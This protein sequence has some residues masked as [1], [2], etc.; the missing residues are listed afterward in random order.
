MF[1]PLGWGDLIAA[2]AG[3][4]VGVIW[5]TARRFRF[6]HSFAYW[7]AQRLFASKDATPK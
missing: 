6:G 4:V 2:C 7:A 1:D 3:M 5:L